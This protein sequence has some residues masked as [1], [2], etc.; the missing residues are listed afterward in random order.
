MTDQSRLD[1]L[2]FHEVTWCA[3]ADVTTVVMSSAILLDNN[4]HWVSIKQFLL[5]VVNFNFSIYNGL[6][7]ILSLKLFPSYGILIHKYRAMSNYINIFIFLI[8]VGCGE[9]LL[10]ELYHKWRIKCWQ[11]FSALK[12]GTDSLLLALRRIMIWPS[13]STYYITFN[14]VL[15][16]RWSNEV[17]ER[18]FTQ[19]NQIG[20]WIR[21]D[22][23]DNILVMTLNVLSKFKIARHRMIEKS[24]LSQ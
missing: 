22:G 20:M 19:D 14:W 16:F 15:R 24:L 23:T 5:T 4:L 2:V 12:K 8:Y 3:V 18:V 17:Q 21:K 1:V 13:V 11:H 7:K 10:L 6:F 9:P